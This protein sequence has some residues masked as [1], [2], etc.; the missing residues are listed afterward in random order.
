ME[1]PALE[2]I[3]SLSTAKAN[4]FTEY[5]IK[6]EI[7]SNK[8][9]IAFYLPQFHP[10]KENNEFWG[11]GFTEWR[12]VTKAL[13]LF[14]GHIQPR[15]PSNLGYYDLRV[16]DTIKMQAE[17][18]TNYGISAF[19]LYYY[20]FDSKKIMD[21]VIETIFNNKQ[22]KTNYCVFWAN[23]NWTRNWDGNKTNVLIP[24]L[25]SPEDDIKFIAEIS[26]YFED[27]RY[28]KKDGRPVVMI[29]RPS[30]FANPRDTTD[31][32]KNWCTKNGFPVP[33]LMMSQAFTNANMYANPVQFGYDAAFEFPPHMGTACNPKEYVADNTVDWFFDKNKNTVFKYSTAVNVWSVKNTY[34]FKHYKTVFPNW[35]NS[36]R[37]TN[38]NALI[39]Y[40]STPKLYEDWLNYCLDNSDSD[41]YV[42]I[43][44]WNEWAEGAYL[45][46]DSFN[47]CAYLD[48]TYNALLKH[49]DK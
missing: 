39:Y 27:E 35:D 44:A 42:F 48:A 47:G 46:P 30:I 38:G 5:E 10:L 37:R 33:Y 40:N 24:Q 31:R 17:Y 16:T 28:V 29:Y 3:K 23:E 15:Q 4:H 13:P 34:D 14:N 49:K 18:A 41:D 36:P 25:H 9:L 11:E 26:K 8:K 2:Y 20:W 6:P 12:N 45:E 22:I 21:T 7:K 32:W 1:I 43:N 19:A